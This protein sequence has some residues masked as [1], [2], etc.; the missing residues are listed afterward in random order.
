MKKHWF[1]PSAFFALA[2]LALGAAIDGKWTAEVQGR[3]GTTTQTLTLKA[4]GSK[5]TG[6]L[7]A[8]RGGPANISD[9]M[10]MGNDV[11]FKITQEFNGNSFTRSFKGT[12]AGDDLKLTATVEGGGGGGGGKGG[13]RGPQEMTFKRA[14]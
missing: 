11:M 13:G 3:N 9:G 8:G 5:L 2:C 4:D 1:L 10:I 14:K 12:L 7:D 6:S